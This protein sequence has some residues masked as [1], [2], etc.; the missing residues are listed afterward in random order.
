MITVEDVTGQRE[1]RVEL[2]LGGV[3]SFFSRRG[4][5]SPSRSPEGSLEQEVVRVKTDSCILA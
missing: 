4:S 5:R 2:E 3:A 1:A